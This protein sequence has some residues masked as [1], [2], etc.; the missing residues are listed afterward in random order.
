MALC[1]GLILSLTAIASPR[2]YLIAG[3]GRLLPESCR[4]VVDEYPRSRS[5]LLRLP[6]VGADEHG[7]KALRPERTGRQHHELGLDPEGQGYNSSSLSICIL[8]G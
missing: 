7:H 8:K 1:I 6:V 3:T 2:S 5:G 4:L